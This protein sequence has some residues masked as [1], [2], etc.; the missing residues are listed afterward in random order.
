MIALGGVNL[1]LAHFDAP[2]KFAL[3][4]ATAKSF[5]EAVRENCSERVLP[6][7]HAKAGSNLANIYSDRD[8]A[9]SERAYRSN[10][11]TSIGLQKSALDSISKSDDPIGWG[12]LQHNLGLSYTNFFQVQSDKS[13]SMGLIE[14]AIH[15][16]DLSFEV[17]DSTSVLQYWVASCRSLGEALIE[18][19]M[20]QPNT[21]AAI[22]LERADTILREAASRISE[23]EHP[24]QWAEV[25]HQLARCLEQRDSGEGQH[26]LATANTQG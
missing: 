14:R 12:I 19:S 23:S 25:Q 20:Y 18:S 22:C 26:P 15:H 5:Y 17:R 4:I 3:H 16:L 7:Y 21:Q 1:R 10:L 11:E 2:D 24:H 6:Y 9:D 13:Q 8:F